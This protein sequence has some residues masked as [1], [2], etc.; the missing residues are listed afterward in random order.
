MSRMV[1]CGIAG[2]C[3]NAK[4]GCYHINPHEYNP[5]NTAC[6][7]TYHECAENHSDG[8]IPIPV[9][10]HIYVIM[11]VVAVMMIISLLWRN[12]WK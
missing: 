6:L 7:G 2:T 9:H 1:I 12:I 10:P 8:C 11:S 5:D 3:D 4:N